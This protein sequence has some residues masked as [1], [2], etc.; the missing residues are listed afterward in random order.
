MTNS[1]LAP[2]LTAGHIPQCLAGDG[3]TQVIGNIVPEAGGEAE[4]GAGRG[5]EE[6]GDEQETE[7]HDDHDVAEVPGD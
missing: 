5:G 2:T 7:G 3:L 6:A 4:L 1:D